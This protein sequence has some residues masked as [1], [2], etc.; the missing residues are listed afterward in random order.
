MISQSQAINETIGKWIRPEIRALSAYHV[1]DYAN[2][3]KLDAMENPYPWPEDLIEVWLEAL[4]S[5]SI[6]RYPDPSPHALKGLLRDTMGIPGNMEILLGN[7]SDELIQLI[8]MLLQ[9]RMDDRQR[10]LLAPE[11]TF[12][13]Y[14]LIAIATGLEFVGVPLTDKDFAL[15]GDAMLDAIKKHQPAVVFLAYPNNPTGG[16]FDTDVL[17]AILAQAP[18]LV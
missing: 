10:C 17:L 15:D 16:L 13:M 8:A 2:L 11:P 14:R 9:G 5:V 7:G 3:I 18:G 6:N 12:A 4:R 1:P